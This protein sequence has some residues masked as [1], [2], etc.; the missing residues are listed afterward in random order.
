MPRLTHETNGCAPPPRATRDAPPRSHLFDETTL[1]EGRPSWTTWV[2][3][4]LLGVQFDGQNF[5]VI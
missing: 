3:P 5:E 1:R 2:A 4:E